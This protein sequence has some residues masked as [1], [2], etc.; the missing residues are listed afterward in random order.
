MIGE[1]EDQD[2]QAAS[3]DAQQEE[4]QDARRLITADMIADVDLVAVLTPVAEDDD[5]AVEKQLRSAEREAR[6]AGDINRGDVLELFASIMF[7]A[8]RPDDE[9][10]PFAAKLIMDGRR[11]M[12]PDDIVGAQSA[13]LADVVETLPSAHLRAKVGDIVFYNNRK[14]WK[15]AAVAIDAYCE[16]AQGRLNDTIRPRASRPADSIMDVVEPLARA[17]ALTRL[18]KKRGEIPD[19]V[20]QSLLACYDAARAGNHYVVFVKTA[21]LGTW[22][23]NPRHVHLGRAADQVA[24]RQAHCSAHPYVVGVA[25]LHHAMPQGDWNG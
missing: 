5:Y 4:P 2:P 7:I 12:I 10:N 15:A 20:R 11:S 9:V 22:Y 1:M 17:T 14:H 24:T 6:A 23:A 18:T 25:L 16:I 19:V 21:E 3:E 13:V 8:V